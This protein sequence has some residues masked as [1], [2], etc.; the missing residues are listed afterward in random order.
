[1]QVLG[2]IPGTAKE[3]KKEEAHHVKTKRAGHSR[4][5]R[6]QKPHQGGK[7][8]HGRSILVLLKPKR[9]KME[10]EYLS[11]RLWETFGAVFK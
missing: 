2:L 9:Q 11:T 8:R 7:K 10:P 3:K 4:Q 6:Q 5:R 1:V